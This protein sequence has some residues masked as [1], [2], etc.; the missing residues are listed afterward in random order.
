MVGKV[1]HKGRELTI[2]LAP[3]I[4]VSDPIV[5]VCS[6]ICRAAATYQRLQEQACNG[7]QDGQ[8]NWDERAEKRAQAKEAR[9]EKRITELCLELPLV[10][11]KPI[12]PDF[13]GDPRGATVKLVMPDG[14]YDDLG[15]TG[16]CVP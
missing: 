4:G 15:Q 1:T 5:H 6:A 12:V 3:S 14:R 10:A 11:G 8:G 13:H 7:Y 9:L 2:A 16:I